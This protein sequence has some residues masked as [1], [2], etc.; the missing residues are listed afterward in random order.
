VGRE[1]QTT[2]HGSLIITTLTGRVT[3]VSEPV[4]G[5]QHDM[6]KLEGSECEMILTLAGDAIGD[7]G[8]IGTDDI[9]TPIRKPKRPRPVPGRT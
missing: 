6:A 3:F 8:F 5:S 2:G 4:P 1:Y 9:I 7:K